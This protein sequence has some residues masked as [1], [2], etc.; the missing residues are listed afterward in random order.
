MQLKQQLAVKDVVLKA[1]AGVV[2]S[3]LG[4]PSTEHRQR[5]AEMAK[6]KGT[7]HFMVMTCLCSLA[8]K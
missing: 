6:T 7:I 1:K 3:E 2:E 5:A 4:V 8:M